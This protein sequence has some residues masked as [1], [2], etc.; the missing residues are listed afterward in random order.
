LNNI[1]TLQLTAERAKHNVKISQRVRDDLELSLHF[2]KAANTGISMNLMTFRR[3][4]KT[5]INDASE[6]GLGGFATH[7]RAWRWVIPEKL[8]GRAH[9]NLLEFIAQLISIWI[10]ICE[11]TTEAQDCLLGMGDSTAAMGWLRHPNFR[12][13]NEKDIEWIIKQKIARQVAKLVLKSETVLYRQWFRGEDNVIADSLSRDCFF[14]S[15]VA[16]ERFLSLSVPHQLPQD[17]RIQP[18]PEEISSFVCSMLVQLPVQKQRCLPPKP[19]N[20]ARSETGKLS[21][22]VSNWRNQSFWTN[23][24]SSNAI[25][26]LQPLPKPLEKPPSLQDLE[27]IWL[28]AQS[29]PPSH[30]WLR[31]SG[32]TTGRIPDWTQTA[33]PASLFR[34][35]CERTETKMIIIIIRNY[36]LG[37]HSSTSA[38][39]RKRPQLGLKPPH[40][41]PP[42][43]H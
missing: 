40:Y 28:R 38:C 35:R 3:P 43:L 34:N 16:H 9:I 24:H 21:L 32:Q 42:P 7:G 26:S 13:K 11:G 37:L 15:P 19:S 31:P 25:S 20:L 17:F 22:I 39:T 36:R 18:V 5:Y 41:L 1:R 10:D 33:R 8:R 12:E 23:S 27:L 14:L 4:D 29:M 30:M 6:H 2:L